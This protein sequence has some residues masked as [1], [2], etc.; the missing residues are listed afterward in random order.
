MVLLPPCDV[1][2][3]GCLLFPR[4]PREAV[5]GGAAPCKLKPDYDLCLAP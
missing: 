4:F 3:V 5:R 1:K 2:P